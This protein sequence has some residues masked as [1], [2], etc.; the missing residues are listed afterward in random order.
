MIL[1]EIV[2]I[3]SPSF[4]NCITKVDGWCGSELIP[5]SNKTKFKRLAD[6]SRVNMAATPV[7]STGDCPCNIAE[8][9]SKNN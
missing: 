5:S 8:K 1:T 6:L 9:D 4:L 7:P 2:S 3:T